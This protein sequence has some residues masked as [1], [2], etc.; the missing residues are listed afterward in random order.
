MLELIL[1]PDISL[2]H[3]SLWKRNKTPYNKYPE[4][5]VLDLSDKNGDEV[6]MYTAISTLPTEPGMVKNEPMSVSKLDEKM[7]KRIKKNT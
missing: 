6:E 7:E 1:R 3:E 2:Y 5:V 4:G